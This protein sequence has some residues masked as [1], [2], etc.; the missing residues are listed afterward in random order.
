MVMGEG[1][2][3]GIEQLQALGKKHGLKRAAEILGQVRAGV[4]RWRRHAD[5]AGVTAKSA[6]QIGERIRT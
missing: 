1:K 2:T 6:K 4:S 3:P 5:N